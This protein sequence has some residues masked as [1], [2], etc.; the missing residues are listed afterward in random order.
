MK[1]I[2]LLLFTF[3]FI[4]CE[5]DELTEVYNNGKGGASCLINEKV[6]ND[7]TIYGYS[8]IRF[9]SQADGTNFF[10]IQLVNRKNDFF[11]D[12]HLGI[13]IYGYEY[14]NLEGKTFEIKEENFETY[15]SYAW[16]SIPSDNEYYSDEYNSYSE[17]IGYLKVTYFNKDEWIIS[18]TFQF[19]LINENNEVIKITEGRFDLQN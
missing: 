5:K 2:I 11:G 19:N 7:R 10:V 17:N 4:S 1:K 14:E 16:L 18:G 6:L 9:D 12:T 15:N 13:I 3:I 8:R